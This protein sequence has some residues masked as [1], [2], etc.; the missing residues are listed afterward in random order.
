[1]VRYCV[2]ATCRKHIGRA[3]LD[4]LESALPK[5]MSY[6]MIFNKRGLGVG[7]RSGDAPVDRNAPMEFD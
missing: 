7:C 2:V 1:V 6:E 4:T 3:L 5:A